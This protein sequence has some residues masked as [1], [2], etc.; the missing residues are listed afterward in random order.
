MPFFPFVIVGFTL[1][2]LDS[3][4]MLLQLDV[5][6]TKSVIYPHKVFKGCEKYYGEYIA[7][8]FL[9]LHTLNIY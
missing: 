4:T 1:F 6:K 9:Y 7:Y 3:L 8:I 2:H 5:F